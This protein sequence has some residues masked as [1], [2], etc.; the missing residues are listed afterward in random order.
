MNFGRVIRASVVAGVIAI[1]AVTMSTPAQASAQTC[2]SASQGYVCT[3]V[4]GS[5]TW[6]SQMGVSRGKAPSAIC[7]YSAWFFYVP[8][9]GG[10]YGLGYQS[11]QGCVLG[12]AWFDIPVNRNF[13][14]GTLLCAQWWEDY[15]T[16]KVAE[17]C[18]GV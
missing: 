12:R 6:V 11:R 17:K 7:N 2:I 1:A 15:H 9:S 13:Q 16:V 4:V 3:N 18:V 10:A 14:H 8:P 5:G